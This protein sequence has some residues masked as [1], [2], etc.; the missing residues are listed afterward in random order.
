MHVEIRLEIVSK[1]GHKT[2]GLDRI[3]K[4]ANFE[5]ATISLVRDWDVLV[6]EASREVPKDFY[7]DVDALAYIDLVE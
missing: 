6:R 4:H 2:M 1:N 5:H 7:K 3:V